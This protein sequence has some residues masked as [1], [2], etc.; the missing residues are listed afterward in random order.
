MAELITRTPDP[1]NPGK[2]IINV[3]KIEMHGVG[4]V[5]N[6]G[7]PGWVDPKTGIMV[8]FLEGE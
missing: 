7:D 5:R 1:D 3:F 6:P 8:P 2:H 4:T